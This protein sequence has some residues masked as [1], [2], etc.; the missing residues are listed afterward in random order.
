MRNIGRTLAL[1]VDRS[2]LMT[3]LWLGGTVSVP[4][5]IRSS[6]AGATVP[7][8][9]FLYRLLKILAVFASL[10]ESGRLFHSQTEKMVSILVIFPFFFLANCLFLHQPSQE[11]DHC[12]RYSLL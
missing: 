9:W 6:P 8:Q 11:I 4:R 3:M 7:M 10:T 5:L 1:S 2:P 12:S